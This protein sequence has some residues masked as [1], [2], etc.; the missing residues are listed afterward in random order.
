MSEPYRIA[1]LPDLLAPI[2]LQGG[3][4]GAIHEDRAGT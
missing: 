2:R 3:S 1:F 4:I